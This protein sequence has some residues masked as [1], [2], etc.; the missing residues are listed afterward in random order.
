MKRTILG[1]LVTLVALGAVAEPAAAKNYEVVDAN[2]AMRLADNG[3]LLVREDLT[4]DFDGSFE[5]A[6][7]DIPLLEGQRI[8][9]VQVSE[10]NLV[11][12]PGGNTILGSFDRPGVFGTEDSIDG[13]RGER[14]VWHYR[15]ANEVRTFTVTYRVR[16]GATAYDD[17]IDIGWTVWGDQWDFDLDHLSASRM[18]T[19]ASTTS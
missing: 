14:V 8:T 2:V 9:D 4:F 19:L 3:D 17:V 12:N 10:S 1:A 13:Q 6:Y 18:A 11:Y 16:G 15:A 5:G 7:R